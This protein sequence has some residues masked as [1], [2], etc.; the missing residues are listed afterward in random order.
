M[1]RHSCKPNHVG[2][3]GRLKLAILVLV[4]ARQVC[5]GDHVLLAREEKEGVPQ[6]HSLAEVKSLYQ[7]AQVKS[8]TS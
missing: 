4:F 6:K 7:T 1:E 5:P 3:A 2:M 8:R